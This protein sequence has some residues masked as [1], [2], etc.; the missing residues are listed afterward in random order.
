MRRKTDAARI[1][2]LHPQLTIFFNWFY[3]CSQI[4]LLCVKWGF[5]GD[6]KVLTRHIISLLSLI[7]LMRCIY[8]PPTT[9]R[10]LYVAIIYL[11]MY[12]LRSTA[13]YRR[14]IPRGMYI[15]VL[16]LLHINNNSN[17]T[18]FLQFP[19]LTHLNKFQHYSA[20][21]SLACSIYIHM[22]H[23]YDTFIMH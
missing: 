2:F 10:N 19:V 6:T 18:P 11:Y 7:S 16:L 5:S 1:F 20:F 15:P 13:V 17:I 14:I 4:I 21:N 9:D 23:M 8:V 22:Y 12:L 3:F